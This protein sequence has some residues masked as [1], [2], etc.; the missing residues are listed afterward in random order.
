MNLRYK[1]IA[2]VDE[3]G[4]IGYQ[5]KLPFSLR[6]DIAY[7]RKC[8]E[9]SIII[10]T[11]LTVDQVGRPPRGSK[12]WGV[13]RDTLHGPHWSEQFDD[14]QQAV[15]QA[16]QRGSTP[17][18]IGGEWLFAE[19]LPAATELYITRVA[20]QWQA[21]RFFPANWQ[22]QFPVLKSSQHEEENG[23]QFA[24]EVRIAERPN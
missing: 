7:F 6:K 14:W 10:G 23:I 16:N 15:K 21:D 22:Q 17:W 4:G 1:I 8:V 20:G 2:A 24:W 9:D 13:S 3:A 5:G 12:I 11:R 18:I 19:A